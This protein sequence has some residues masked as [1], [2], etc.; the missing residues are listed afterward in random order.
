MTAERRSQHD[1]THTCKY[2]LVTILRPVL[3][4]ETLASTSS[5]KDA[6]AAAE[7]ASASAS[8]YHAAEF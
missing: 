1:K 2:G 4:S 3:A 6:T 5:S 7:A 8:M